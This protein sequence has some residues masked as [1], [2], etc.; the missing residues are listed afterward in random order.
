M[1]SHRTWPLLGVVMTLIVAAGCTN[2]LGPSEAPIELETLVS[3]DEGLGTHELL[4]S[5]N[6]PG[7]NTVTCRIG[8]YSRY[9]VAYCR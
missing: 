8:G 5:D 7:S 1:S 6:Q 3:T 2:D 4:Q 9:A